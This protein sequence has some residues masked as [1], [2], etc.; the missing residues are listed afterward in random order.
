MAKR[1]RPTDAGVEGG[2]RPIDGAKVRKRT[3]R[4]E[5]KIAELEATE[6]RRVGQL[7]KV[8]ASVADLRAR[9]AALTLADAATDATPASAGPTSGPTGYCMREKRRVQIGDPV[10][11][12]LSN[13][14]AA[15]AGT[16]LT[17]GARIVALT[18]RAAPSGG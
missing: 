14:R 11:V 8:R 2:S 17:C 10:P 7:E 12:T 9:L 16:C 15:T 3:R 13:G 6:A 5:R 4:L 18:P 1:S